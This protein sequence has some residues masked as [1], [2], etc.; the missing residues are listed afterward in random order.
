MPADKRTQIGVRP[1][2]VTLASARGL[3]VQVRR[4]DDLGRKRLAHVTLGGHPLV[5]TVPDGMA[6]IGTE[7]FVSLDAAHVLVYRD[8]VRVEGVAA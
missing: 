4:I 3:K 6:T 1:D 2:F 7:A 5:A 8:D